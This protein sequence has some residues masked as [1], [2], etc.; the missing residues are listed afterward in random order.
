MGLLAAPAAALIVLAA[1]ALHGRGGGG[2][3]SAATRPRPVVKVVIPEGE[4]QQGIAE[5][6]RARGLT[7][8]YLAAAAPAGA[9]ARA[10]GFDPQR[11]GAPQGAS[12]EG[13]LFPATYELYA[14]SPAS[15]L[16]AEQLEAFG[17]HFGPDL[18]AAARARHLTPYEL[19][20]VA[21]IV[22]REAGVP[23]DRPLI[24]AVIYNRLR[25][26]M[27]LGVD[28]TLRY[29]LHDYTRP[30]TQAQLETHTPYNTRLH[31]GLPPTPIANPG[32]E[33]I[34]AA[35]H[36]AQVGYLYYVAAPDGCGESVFASSYGQFLSDVAAYRS[37]LAA[38]GGRVPTCHRR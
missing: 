27:P 24:A 30:L 7:G 37:A 29:A 1:L 14:G 11:Y 5:I 13:F 6:A 20:T 25:L 15:R 17:E 31:R 34:E 12:L 23:H 19:L 38:N 35:A 32:M 2:A 28:A 22:E 9:A 10:L 4:T 26:G 8:S 36:P 21:S 18:R 3:G 33:A 16:V